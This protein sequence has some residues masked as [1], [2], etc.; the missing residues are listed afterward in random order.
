MPFAPR[1]RSR[2]SAPQ[3]RRGRSTPR[4]Q[5]RLDRSRASR[6]TLGIK[7]GQPIF[8]TSNQGRRA[9]APPYAV[10]MPPASTASMHDSPTRISTPRGSCSICPKGL[11]EIE[12]E[13]ADI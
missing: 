11:T 13:L 6:T 3:H 10:F 4:A 12:R 1:G 5:R 7:I 9:H 8:I 2:P